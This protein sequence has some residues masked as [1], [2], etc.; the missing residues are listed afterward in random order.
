MSREKTFKEL[1]ED[2]KS[3]PT[4]AQAFISEIA[5]LTCSNE[6]TVRMWLTGRQRPDALAQRVLAEHFKT[7]AEALFPKREEAQAI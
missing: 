1:Y 5:E 4:P 6:M 3:L 7:S 2:I